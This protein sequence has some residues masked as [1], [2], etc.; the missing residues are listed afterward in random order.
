MKIIFQEATF[1]EEGTIEDLANAVS[2]FL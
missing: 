1:T 2:E